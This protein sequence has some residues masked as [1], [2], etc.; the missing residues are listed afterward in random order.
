MIKWSR[1]QSSFS[2]KSHCLNLCFSVME[3]AYEYKGSG[4]HRLTVLINT[5]RI[6]Y[7]FK[8]MPSVSMT[9]DYHP[10][11]QLKLQS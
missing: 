10:C 5:L 8:V 1:N 6:D 2:V 4:K 7:R 11:D 9:F 3:E